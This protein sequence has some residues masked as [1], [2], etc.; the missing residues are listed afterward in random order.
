MR[1]SIRAG[2][3]A[4][5]LVAATAVLT[6][7]APQ[8]PAASG[9]VPAGISARGVGEVTGTPDKVSID[10]AVATRSANAQTALNDNAAKSAALRDQLKAKGVADADVQT[11]R[12]G[13]DP[14]FDTNGRIAG[15]EVTNQLTVTIRDVATAGGIIDAAAQAA[16]DAVRVQSLGFS[17]D[18]DS[19]LLAQARAAAVKKAQEQAKQLADAA[20]VSLG[21]IRTITETSAGNRP[22]PVP[23]AAGVADGAEQASKVSPGT[24]QL[25]VTVEIVYNIG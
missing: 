14:T 19:K 24:Q 7:C 3:A 11:S 8:P 4:A 18:D 13:I 23:Y 17:I 6:G 21:S 9:P 2:L 10:L 15:Y 25:S 5:G 20:G 16:G 1:R 22:P 12:F